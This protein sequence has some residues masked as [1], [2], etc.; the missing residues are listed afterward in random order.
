MA[1]W[2]GCG[3][4][5]VIG[6]VA[7]VNPQIQSLVPTRGERERGRGYKISRILL[8]MEI[9]KQKLSIQTKPKR[10]PQPTRT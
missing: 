6:C 7:S 5:L 10:K 4:C 9:L 8:E 2:T 3:C 1:R